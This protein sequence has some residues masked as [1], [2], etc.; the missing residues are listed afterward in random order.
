MQSSQVRDVD[1]QVAPFLA[2]DMGRRAVARLY[3]SLVLFTFV[4]TP[5]QLIVVEEIQ[6]H[7]PTIV[8]ATPCWQCSDEHASLDEQTKLANLRDGPW[9]K[10]ILPALVT[11]GNYRLPVEASFE[12][13]SF[14]TKLG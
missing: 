6:R 12:F 13:G 11:S 4:C 2:V 14:D 5:G 1:A 3:P 7:N 8:I 10:I 9:R